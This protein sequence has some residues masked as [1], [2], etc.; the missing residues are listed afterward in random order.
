MNSDDTRLSLD[1]YRI[2]VLERPKHCPDPG[3][4]RGV[5]VEVDVA[6]RGTGLSDKAQMAF[7]ESLSTDL[8]VVAQEWA[9][10]LPRHAAITLRAVTAAAQADISQYLLVLSNAQQASGA[11]KPDS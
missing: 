1:G 5:L 6:L 9:H 11:E 3:R 10:L 4:A 2:Q 7:W 8:D